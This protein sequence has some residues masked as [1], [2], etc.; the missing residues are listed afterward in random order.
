[1]TKTG[2]AARPPMAVD[3]ESL[4]ETFQLYRKPITIAAV[5]LAAVVG[6]AF[7]WQ[8]STARKAAQAEKAFYDAVGLFGRGDPKAAAELGKVAQRYDGTA[9]GTQAALLLAQ[10]QFDEGKFDDGLKVLD[11]VSRPGV[12]ASGVESLKAAGY[13][14]KEQYDKAAEHYLSAVANA[15][16]SGEKE[17]LQ[18]E[19]A[20][21]LAAAGKKAEALKIWEELAAKTDSPMSGEAKIR[22]GELTAAPITK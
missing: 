6:G 12:F 22:V 1:M 21:A 17:F 5:V 4:L 13:E 19:A 11:G 16:L 7:L 20:R 15:A 2:E 3:P 8:A 18:G 9:G 10:T 14:G